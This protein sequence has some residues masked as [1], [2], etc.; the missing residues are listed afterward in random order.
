MTNNAM[1]R[2]IYARQLA[3]AKGKFS[4]TSEYVKKRDHA[5]TQSCDA[6]GS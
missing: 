1:Q 5:V 4:I 2:R 6:E 3:R